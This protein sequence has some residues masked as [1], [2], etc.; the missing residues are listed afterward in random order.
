MTHEEE[1]EKLLTQRDAFIVKEELWQK[2]VEEIY[3]KLDTTRPVQTR[4]GIRCIAW[5]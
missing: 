4:E 3:P 2:F 1:L 5:R